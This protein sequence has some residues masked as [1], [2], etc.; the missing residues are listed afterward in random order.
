MS[1]SALC[2]FYRH[3]SI[4]MPRYRRFSFGTLAFL[5]VLLLLPLL[6]VSCSQQL[7]VSVNN[8]A[9]FDPNNRLPSGE[10]LNADL[11]GCIN[12]A[13]RQQLVTDPAQLSVLSCA[14]SEIDSLENVGQLLSLRFLD[15]SGN[16]ISNI[17]PLETLQVLGGLNLANNE[18]MDIAV[19]LNLKSLVSVSLAGN[20]NIPCSQIAAL[21]AK[22]K[23]QFTEPQSCRN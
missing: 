9:V 3:L 6:T 5:R 16:S 22:L 15:L 11:Q 18:I 7:A 21:R 1:N 8:R 2:S 10:A 12:L 14:N 4:L 13:M 20:N 17:T 19:L 23:N